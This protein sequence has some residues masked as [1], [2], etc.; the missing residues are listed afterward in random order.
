MWENKPLNRYMLFWSQCN[1]KTASRN[2]R[3]GQNQVQQRDNQIS[4]N[5]S[6]QAAA[7][8]MNLRCHVFTP[9]R[10][11]TDQRLPTQKLHQPR[12]LPGSYYLRQ[13]ELILMKTRT[14]KLAELLN[15]PT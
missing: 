11:L 1:Q 9:E 12:R 8:N 7:Q 4:S 15:R 5:K 13:I 6:A 14:L 3:P 10:W 2:R